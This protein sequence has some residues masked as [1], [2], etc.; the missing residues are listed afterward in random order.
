MFA[1]TVFH[2]LTPVLIPQGQSLDT[3]IEIFHKTNA[4][5]LVTQAGILPPEKL[6][7]SLPE[8]R[9]VVFVVEQ[10]SRHMDWT[11]NTS[12]TSSKPKVGIWHDIVKREDEGTSS[13]PSLDLPEKELGNVITVRQNEARGAMEVNEYT[14]KVRLMFHLIWG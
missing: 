7:N 1:A 12:S 8:L 13:S 5:V 6:A 4:V 3:L 2:G 9:Q 11:H 10:A 14:Q